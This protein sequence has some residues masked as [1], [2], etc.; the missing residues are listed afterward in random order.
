MFDLHLKYL[1]DSYIAFFQERKRIEDAYIY[2]LLKLHGKVKAIDTQLEERGDPSTVRSAWREVRD[3]S[4]REAQTRQAFLNS[5]MSDVLNPLISFRETQDRTRKRIKED[6]KQSMDAFNEYADEVIPKLKRNYIRKCQD[7]DEHRI[8]N[9]PPVTSP[10]Q[11]T[12]PMPSSEGRNAP[13][14]PPVVTGPQPLRPI[15]RRASGGQPTSRNRS[16]SSGTALADLAHQGK[17]QLNQL[18]TFLDKNNTIKD[19]IGGRSD[20]ALRSVRAKREADDADKEYRKGIHWLETLRIRRKKILEGGYLSLQLFVQDSADLMKNILIK[21]SDNLIATSTTQT[22]LST[23]VRADID[24]IAPAVD[25]GTIAQ[26]VPRAIESAIPPPVLYHN[27][28]V[29]DCEDLIFGVSLVNYAQARG[30]ADNEIPKIVRLC[31]AEVDARG[32]NSEGIY[33]VSGRHAVVQELQRRIERDEKSFRFNPATDD[34]F[35]VGSLL[36]LYL[37]ELPE[38]LFR[39]SLQD[40]IQHSEDFD[41]HKTNN[42]ALLRAKMRRLPPIHL[43]VLRALIEHLVRVTQHVSKNKMDVKNLSI[44]FNSVIFG[45]DELPK[46]GADLLNMQAYKDTLFEDIVENASILFDDRGEAALP[47]PPTGEEPEKVYYGTTHTKSGYIPPTPP[48]R[49]NFYPQPPS[50]ASNSSVTLQT[51]S[52]PSPRPDQQPVFPV[53]PPPPPDFTPQL[54]PRPAN[55]I[56]PSARANSQL[57]PTGPSAQL[58]PPPAP[59]M[60]PE[61]ISSLLPL[62]PPRSVPA[63]LSTQVPQQSPPRSQTDVSTRNIA[64]LPP[65]AQPPRVPPL[66]PR[67]GELSPPLPPLPL[68]PA[69]PTGGFPRVR[70]TSSGNSSSSLSQMSVEEPRGR[71]LAVVGQR[72]DQMRHSTAESFVTAVSTHEG[73]QTPREEVTDT[74][75]VLFAQ[76]SK[77]EA[78]RKATSNRQ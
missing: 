6:I 4:E 70:R 45:E 12:I 76:Q 18:M 2:G 34:V 78:G 40:R 17:R 26:R 14:S 16:P 75:Q 22:Q 27:Y 68:S 11:P 23:H 5:L 19:G 51:P 71:S 36:K 69:Q 58:P 63:L 64:P 56:H 15:T 7:A 46:A 48:R 54:P 35:V 41:E 1:S 52:T 37:R 9:Q 44:V 65:G 32:L 42:F 59:V 39:F 67:A 8:S 31:I 60:V 28:V 74:A 53:S 13:N 73:G 66:P 55:S 30:L 62:P 20:A 25:V 57:S 33:R 38:P 61:P 21:Y 49:E 3:H 50:E 72:P 47:P 43:A 29:G 77:E 24:R 10:T